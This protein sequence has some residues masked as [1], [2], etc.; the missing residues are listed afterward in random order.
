MNVTHIRAGPKRKRRLLQ[1]RSQKLGSWA[2]YHLLCFV[3]APFEFVAWLIEQRKGLTT[4][5][6]ANWRT[7]P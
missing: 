3:Q 5:R 6:L 2:E 4:D 1:R 7:E